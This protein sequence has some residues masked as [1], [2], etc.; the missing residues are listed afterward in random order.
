LESGIINP[1]R[2]AGLQQRTLKILYEIKSLKYE[3][4]EQRKGLAFMPIYSKFLFLPL[5]RFFE[6]PG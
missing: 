2:A 3:C 5:Y 1:G 4:A 6:W